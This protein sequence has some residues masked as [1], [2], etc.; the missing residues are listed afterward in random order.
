MGA[1]QIIQVIRPW[2]RIETY[3]D[4]GILHDLKCLW[5]MSPWNLGLNDKT[6]MS[7]THVTVKFRASILDW[8]Y[9]LSK[10]T[11]IPSQHATP[12]EKP[13]LKSR[14]ILDNWDHTM[15]CLILGGWDSTSTPLRLHSL[16]GCLTRQH[17][18]CSS[19]R[20]RSKCLG[21]TTQKMG[22]L[23]IRRPQQWAGWARQRKSVVPALSLWRWHLAAPWNFA[24]DRETFRHWSAGASSFGYA[25][26]VTLNLFGVLAPLPL[27]F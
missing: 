4:L 15:A 24:V 12:P 18:C 26:K 11:P 2:L 17:H 23:Y 1:P 19:L 14:E 3:G 5:H 16:R 7:M 27:P 20:L 8:I 13:W 25:V 10:I 22:A 6:T 21:L 9:N